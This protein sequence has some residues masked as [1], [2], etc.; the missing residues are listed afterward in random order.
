[1]TLHLVSPP[2]YFPAQEM[3]DSLHEQGDVS[4]SLIQAAHPT[5]IAQ[6]L[7]RRGWGHVW[8]LM[9]ERLELGPHSSVTAKVSTALP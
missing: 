9:A 4:L 1:M 8:Q 5:C 3:V 2:L 6:A 7:Y